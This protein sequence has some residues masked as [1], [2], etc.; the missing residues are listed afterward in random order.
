MGL[1]K[2]II[3]IESNKALVLP[4]NAMESAFF[5]C[6]KNNDEYTDFYFLKVVYSRD[7]E[8]VGNKGEGIRVPRKI[9]G[10]DVDPL[11]M[12]LEKLASKCA[13]WKQKVDE[14]FFA[15]N[16]E[17]LEV[18]FKLFFDVL[19]E[20]MERAVLTLKRGSSDFQVY[21]KVV[22]GLL[23]LNSL[24]IRSESLYLLPKNHPI[25]LMQRYVEWLT[26]QEVIEL[27]ASNVTEV[28]KK[29]IEQ[30]IETKNQNRL[31]FYL[32]SMNKVY[33]VD[34]T[35]KRESFYCSVPFKKIKAN[36]EI[37]AVR[38]WQKVLNTSDRLRKESNIPKEE[39]VT[40][41]VAVFGELLEEEILQELCALNQVEVQINHFRKMYNR[42]G[43]FFEYYK[44]D[45]KDAKSKSGNVTE[46]YDL[47]YSPDLDALFAK[48]SLV[49]LLDLNCFYEQRQ[50]LKDIHEKNELV[51]CHWYM[52]R[53]SQ[54]KAFKDKAACYQL[55]FNVVSEWLNSYNNDMSSKYEFNERLYY[56][57]LDNINDSSDVYLYIRHGN[58][59]AGKSLLNNNV[60]SDEYYDG[61]QLIVYKFIADKGQ[62]NSKE[63]H[64]F[65]KEGKNHRV[66]INIWKILKSINNSY[67]KDFIT[68]YIN[69]NGNAACAK[70]IRQLESSY[71]ILDYE[72]LLNGKKELSYC[73]QVHDKLEQ[74]VKRVLEELMEVILKYTLEN[75]SIICV[76][77]YFK[78][79]IMQSIISNSNNVLDIIFA[80]LLSK[81]EF[82]ELKLIK[83]EDIPISHEGTCFAVRKTIQSII[84]NLSTLGL[85]GMEDR[86]GYFVNDFRREICPKVD[87]DD[88]KN[89]IKKINDCCTTFQ[90]TGSQL[91]VNS[92]W[93]NM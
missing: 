85:R 82:K 8:F 21:C 27:P 23:F 52:E 31:K 9:N 66:R 41:Y 92:D 7:E 60:C 30:I 19:I 22:K 81:E 63:Y 50:N 3:G 34:A 5:D 90:H 36:T 77:N 43:F 73:L 25:I 53:A 49:L 79:L 68:D 44:P 56:S 69:A 62:D 59:I 13:I 76:H 65:L 78:N 47:L 42:G 89:I 93:T 83:K 55:I 86:A 46:F 74:N 87:V 15:N 51:N 1:L 67:F 75:K 91:Y 57:L 64:D 58:K 24:G 18:T 11:C 54:F 4:E 48:Y 35:N 28:G 70:A 26:N 6:Q 40:V 72:E 12:H 2:H 88:F 84:E 16:A 14:R 29:M 17:E 39:V 71:C 20:A 80:Y 33:G 10:G 61:R 45:E 32:Y 37:P 38:I